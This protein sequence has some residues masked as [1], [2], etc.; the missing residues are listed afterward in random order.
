MKIKYDKNSDSKYITVSSSQRKRGIVARTKKIHPWLMV[1]YDKAG[2][3]YG[4]EILNTSKHE[5]TLVIFGNLVNYL[6]GK[7]RFEDNVNEKKFDSR[8]EGRLTLSIEN[9]GFSNQ[10][11]NAS[12]ALL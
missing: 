11:R 10:I 5:G 8:E 4:I 9:P 6:E 12:I 3:V 2:N 1:D 7:T